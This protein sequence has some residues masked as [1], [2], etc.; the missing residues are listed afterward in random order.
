MRMSRRLRVAAVFVALA[1]PAG[2]AGQGRPLPEVAGSVV[3]RSPVSGAPLVATVEVTLPRVSGAGR[4]TWVGRERIARDREG[5][6]L[7]EQF[8]AVA[9]GQAPGRLVRSLLQLDGHPTHTF[10]VDHDRREVVA[11]GPGMASMLVGGGSSYVVA[12][13]ARES[14][15]AHGAGLT[16]A[17]HGLGGDAVREETMGSRVI[18]GVP[19]TGRR[20]TIQLPPEAEHNAEPVEIV[21]ERWY[22]EALQLT[23]AARL[24]DPRFG[25]AESRVTSLAMVEPSATLFTW[26]DGYSEGSIRSAASLVFESWRNPPGARRPR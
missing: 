14:L 18:A 11:A 5:R 26:P 10:L 17:F 25:V 15:S 1:A 12:Q 8:A 21:E 7:V 22:S 13:G 4:E 3:S 23:I 19:A 20:V 24:A 16:A 6:V 2:L 9:P